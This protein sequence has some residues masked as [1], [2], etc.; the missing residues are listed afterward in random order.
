MPH[1]S[2]WKEA[3][4]QQKVLHAA[5][6]VVAAVVVTVFVIFPLIIQPVLTSHKDG[7]WGD[8]WTKVLRAWN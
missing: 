2:T 4:T 1:P 8:G 6:L 5:G 7:K 3:S